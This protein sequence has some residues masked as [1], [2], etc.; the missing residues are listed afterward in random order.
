MKSTLTLLGLAYVA[1]SAVAVPAT[2][3][4]EIGLTAEELGLKDDTSPASLYICTGL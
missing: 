1:G 2:Y 3:P 4:E